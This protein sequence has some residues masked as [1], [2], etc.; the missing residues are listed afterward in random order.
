ME[1]CF[2]IPLRS[3]A[4]ISSILLFFT[5]TSEVTL[6]SL[7]STILFISTL[8]WFS[9]MGMP[10]SFSLAFFSSPKLFPRPFRLLRIFHSYRLNRSRG[11]CSF[12]MHTAAPGLVSSIH[13]NY[14]DSH[15]AQVLY[16]IPR[17]APRCYCKGC[18]FS[19]PQR[20]R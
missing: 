1:L 4:G 5:G 9:F 3:H 11:E 18:L 6:L 19:P 12:Q 17:E 13:V 15:V 14:D 8:T 2:T 20:T 16:R 10:P 7:D